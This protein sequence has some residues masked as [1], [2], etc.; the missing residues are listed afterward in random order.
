[1]GISDDIRPKT[2]RPISK[3]VVQAEIK[4][5]RKKIEEKDEG[6]LFQESHEGDFFANTPMSNGNSVG[7]KRAIR[8]P[9]NSKT[10]KHRWVY[11]TIIALAVCTLIGLVVWQNYATIK[12]YVDGSYKKKSSQNLSDIINTTTDS[13]KNYNSQSGASSTPAVTATPTVTAVPTVDK[14]TIAISVLNGSGVKN[15]ATTVANTLKA[16]GFS[17]KG[18]GNA[19]SFNYSK[20]YI[21]YKTDDSSA[22]NLVK[23]ALPDRQTEVSKN[24]SVVGSAYD[25]VVVVGKL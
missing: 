22:A 5:A 18:T 20:T 21:Y 17:V 11:P 19:K 12:S 13:A 15:S 23:A 14:S 25:I 2:Y 24:T 3:K 1:M 10:K 4:V 9:K 7:N 16:A 6:N 8:D